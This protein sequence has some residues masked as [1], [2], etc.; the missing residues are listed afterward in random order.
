MK[1]YTFDEIC[2]SQN[3][4]HDDEFML[5][6]DIPDYTP[7][8]MGWKVWDGEYEKQTYIVKTAKG[9]LHECW[10]NAGQ[11]HSYQTEERFTKEDN[12]LIWTIL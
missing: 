4:N 3:F 5:V 10:P 1:K 8:E 12:I 7:P 9:V 11:M 6:K 2:D